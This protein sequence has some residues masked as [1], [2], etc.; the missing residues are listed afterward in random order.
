MKTKDTQSP[1]NGEERFLEHRRPLA[2]FSRLRRSRSIAVSPVWLLSP[3]INNAEIACNS[4][5]RSPSVLKFHS[6]RG[7]TLLRVIVRQK[8]D[9]R[10]TEGNAERE[11]RLLSFENR[12]IASSAFP[13]TARMTA[14]HVRHKYANIYVTCT[15]CR[16][17]LRFS[18]GGTAIIYRFDI[19]RVSR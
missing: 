13:Q 18:E 19:R 4:N 8:R 12:S 16:R 2:S 3:F 15:D 10:G 9:S 17:R 5:S 1:F 6:I 7:A 14:R 11:R